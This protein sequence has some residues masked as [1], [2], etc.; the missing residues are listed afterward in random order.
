M[1]I[2]SCIHIAE[3]QMSLSLVLTRVKG[4]SAWGP[5]CAK[6]KENNAEE[7]YGEEN[8]LLGTFSKSIGFFDHIKGE[9]RCQETSHMAQCNVYFPGRHLLGD[10]LGS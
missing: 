10:V 6:N 8:L 4:L 1:K 3:N 5:S 7:I 2:S 9:Q